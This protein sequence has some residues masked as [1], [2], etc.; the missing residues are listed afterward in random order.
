MTTSV[1]PP[2]LDQESCRQALRAVIDPEIYQ[3]IADFASP[4]GQENL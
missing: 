1:T 4:V 3:N 2:L